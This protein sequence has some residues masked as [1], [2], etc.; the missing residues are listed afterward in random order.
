M[1]TS[2]ASATEAATCLPTC[3]DCCETRPGPA[4]QPA[5][6]R[7]NP[8][9]T[10]DLSYEQHAGRACCWCGKTLSG[11]A[12]SA[13]ISRGRIGAHVLDTEVY[14]CPECAGD[15]VQE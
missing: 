11:R 8:P 5:V 1:R 7:R 13:G 4:R 10:A 12:V 14:A 2:V 6:T 9:P 15:H 3:A